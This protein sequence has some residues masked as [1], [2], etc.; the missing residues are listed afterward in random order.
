MNRN[1]YTKRSSRSPL[2]AVAT[3]LSLPVLVAACSSN[4]PLP[5]PVTGTPQVT[6]TPTGSRSDETARLLDGGRD[7]SSDAQSA[8]DSSAPSCRCAGCHV[9][10]NRFASVTLPCGTSVCEGNTL[11][12][13][14]A[15][16]TLSVSRC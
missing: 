12:T 3:M 6:D 7:G 9:T 4:D 2:F 1:P 14:S 5:P 16:C 10:L 13:C 11:K 8:S 15:T